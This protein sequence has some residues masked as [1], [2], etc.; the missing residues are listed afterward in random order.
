MHIAFLPE[1]SRPETVID[2]SG[3]ISETPESFSASVVKSGD[4]RNI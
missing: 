1:M 4:K 2:P 3:M